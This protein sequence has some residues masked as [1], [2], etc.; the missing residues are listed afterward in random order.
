MPNYLKDFGPKLIENGYLPVPIKPGNKGCFEKGWTSMRMT[1]NDCDKY[2]GH[3][4]GLL[5]GQGDYPLIAVDVDS[6][7]ETI[8]NRM[9]SVINEIALDCIERVGNAPKTLFL[10][11]AQEA[12]WVKMASSF[13]ADP[14]D[15]EAALSSDKP[16]EA[17]KK[18]S[19]H[20]LELLGCGT[21]FVAYHIHPNT[22]KPYEWSL[23]GDPATVAAKE[24]P[25]LAKEKVQSLIKTFTDICLES[26]LVVVPGSAAS[27]N[28]I[29]LNEADDPFAGY[30]TKIVDYTLE[31]AGRE[32]AVLSSEDRDMWLAVG[33]A[34]HFQFDGSDEAYEKWDEWSAPAST[35]AGP[36]DTRK[37]WASF[38]KPYRGRK[39][40]CPTLKWLADQERKRRQKEERKT[41]LEGLVASVKEA[42][43][44]VELGNV[45]ENARIVSPTDRIVFIKEVQKKSKEIAGIS[46]TKKDI[47]SLMPACVVKGFSMTELG[48]AKRLNDAHAG[49][50]LFATKSE[51][52]YYWGQS[53]WEL[54]TR[55]F[56][57]T[58]AIEVIEDIVKEVETLEDEDQ[59][60]AL[61]NFAE[62]S[63]TKSMMNNMIEIASAF[64]DIAIDDDKLDANK[65]LFGCANGVLDLTT[66]QLLPADPSLHHK[67][68]ISLLSF[69]FSFRCFRQWHP[70]GDIIGVNASL[71]ESALVI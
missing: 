42:K 56:L 17:M 37:T 38:D 35:Y 2:P 57:K 26:G 20:R 60:S 64:P 27:G 34:L 19:K 62:E 1:A 31:D 33:M 47:E 11:R 66:G 4:V 45:I 50:L 5:C 44:M 71:F 12:G 67:P 8:V 28:V 54:T 49:H 24:L 25:M 65:K 58:L 13:F 55:T 6:K 3:G 52:W 48:N 7:N 29:S 41:I 22:N 30:G 70:V 10:F 63:Q 14:E 61:A 18:V 32:M 51:N 15:I 59:K 39:I 36:E 68:N 9:K 23:V 69:R 21:Q 16:K 46:L 43:D 53:H 40:G